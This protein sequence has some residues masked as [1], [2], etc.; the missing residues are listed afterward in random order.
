MIKKLIKR[1]LTNNIHFVYNITIIDE[2]IKYLK[3]KKEF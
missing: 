3:E 1:L 2:K